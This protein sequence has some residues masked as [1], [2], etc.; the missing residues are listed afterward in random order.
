MAKRAQRS[1]AHPKSESVVALYLGPPGVM[2][3]SSCLSFGCSFGSLNE[4]LPA[5]LSVFQFVGI[6][7][8]LQT[9]G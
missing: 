5:R 1:S 4:N 2:M 9:Q 3:I 7:A 6:M 8:E